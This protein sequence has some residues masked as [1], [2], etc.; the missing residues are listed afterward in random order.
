MPYH[1]NLEC[2]TYKSNT[3]LSARQFHI[4]D[5]GSAA[6][7]CGPSLAGQGYGVLQ[8]KPKADEAATVAVAGHSRVRA[9]EALSVGQYITSAASGWASAVG[10]AAT[11]NAKVLGRVVVGAA[12]GSIAVVAID[13]TLI[14]NSAGVI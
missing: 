1:N 2:E 9:G 10:S 12:S 14:I 5:I 6:G 3:D 4:V 7:L 13:R 11:T 8:N